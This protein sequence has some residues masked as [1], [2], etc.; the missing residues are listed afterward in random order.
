MQ[1]LRKQR[2]IH[3]LILQRR[4]LHV[5]QP[6]LQIANPIL[7][8]QRRPVLHHLLG[9][10]HRNH[11]PRPLRQNLRQMPLTRPQIRNHHRRHQRQQHPRNPLPRPPW[12]IRFPEFARHPV[13]ILPAP[14]RPLAPQHLQSTRI[15]ARLRQVP[16]RRRPHRPQLALLQRLSQRVIDVFPGTPIPDQT[17]PPQLRQVG[18]DARLAHPED[19]LNFDHGKLLFAQEKEE[20]QAGF[21]GEKPQGFHD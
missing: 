9:V 16:G 8:S 15:L 20:P 10:I 19:F 11:P 13:K 21:I 18:G 6:I 17:R 4:C 3:T 12:T 2:Q 5:P 14:V 1:R 7:Q